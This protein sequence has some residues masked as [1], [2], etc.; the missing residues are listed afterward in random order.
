MK[1]NKRCVTLCALV[2]YIKKY[3][4]AKDELRKLK[5]ST[6]QKYSLIF[7][8]KNPLKETKKSFKIL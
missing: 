2:I 1:K 7:I 6:M 4:N 3:L 5:S 8:K